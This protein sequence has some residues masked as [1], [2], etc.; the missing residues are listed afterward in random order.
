MH[1]E[2]FGSSRHFITSE[3]RI[4]YEKYKTEVKTENSNALQETATYFLMAD[5]LKM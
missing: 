4:E 2:N 5:L 1:G 3:T